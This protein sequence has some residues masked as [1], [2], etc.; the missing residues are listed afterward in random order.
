MVTEISYNS[1]EGHSS[2]YRGEIE[3]I[4]PADWEKDLR[5]SLAE[6][7]DDNGGISRDIYQ[8]DSEAA[9]AYAKVRAG[10]SMWYPPNLHCLTLSSLSA[11]IKGRFSR[12]QYRTTHEGPSC[13]ERAGNHQEGCEI[14]TRCFL[15]GMHLYRISIYYLGRLESPTTSKCLKIHSNSFLVSKE[16]SDKAMLT[17]LNSAGPSILSVIMSLHL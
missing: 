12:Q 3:F 16:C 17:P 13:E 5:V 14:S 7:K 1:S 6:L 10:T 2:K 11:F 15:Q 8:A 4:Q 9:I